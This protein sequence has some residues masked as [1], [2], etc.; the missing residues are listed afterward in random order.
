MKIAIAQIN[1]FLGNFEYN[2]Q[3]IINFIL[4]A[5]AQEAQLVIFPEACL[6]G[7]HP[8]D[9]LERKAI[10]KEQ[11]KYIKK[12]ERNIPDKISAIFGAITLNGKK[13]GKAIF[14]LGNISSKKQKNKKF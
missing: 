11:L 8:L 5:Q 10:V 12:I 3:V 14:Q 9:L 13:K 1:P 6:F 2:Y 7:Y 4:K